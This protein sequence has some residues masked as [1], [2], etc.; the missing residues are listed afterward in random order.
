[1]T[2]MK[3]NLR[4]WLFLNPFLWSISSHISWLWRDCF[5]RPAR[6]FL[7]VGHAVQWE[8]TT[9]RGWLQGTRL[10][11][12]LSKQ[13]RAPGAHV[14]RS[15]PVT[16]AALNYSRALN[17]KSNYQLLPLAPV[18]STNTSILTLSDILKM[19]LECSSY[20]Y[21]N[22]TDSDIW[23]DPGRFTATY[24]GIWRLLPSDKNSVHFAELQKSVPSKIYWQLVNLR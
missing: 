24:V 13:W 8:M 6:G 9:Q 20:I 16:V 23:S 21:V 2:W 11:W 18:V 12:V 1:M 7:L 19:H 3:T 5:D 22:G 10:Y 14:C 4:R 17:D 15:C